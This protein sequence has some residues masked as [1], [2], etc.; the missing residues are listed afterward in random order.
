MRDSS[1]LCF[2]SLAQIRS[3]AS[4][5]QPSTQP[6]PFTQSY[7]NGRRVLLEAGAARTHQ[8][9]RQQPCVLAAALAP[10]RGHADHPR[11]PPG[12]ADCS[13]PNPQWASLSFGAWICLEVRQCSAAR[14][15]ADCRAQQGAASAD[16]GRAPF[17]SFDSA[18]A[19]TVASACTG[20]SSAARRWTSGAK[21]RSARRAHAHPAPASVR[22]LLTPL[23]PQMRLGGNRALNDFLASY[24]PGGGYETGMSIQQKVRSHRWLAPKVIATALTLASIDQY[25]TWAALQYKDK[26]AALSSSPPEPW[27]P[28]PAPPPTAQSGSAPNSR[29]A[30]AQGVRKARG[31]GNTGGIGSSSLSQET[32]EVDSRRAANE[33]FFSGLGD[34]NASRS[35]DLPPSQGRPLS[36]LSSL[37]DRMR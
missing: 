18:A 4:D 34:K 11:A 27:S 15:I 26:L 29:P 22:P 16:Q 32:D 30:S 24:G 35:T 17:L 1:W 19:C 23:V 12:C 31:F 13:N 10:A 33:T 5:Q 9:G 8:A 14:R 36:L 21:T 6:P 25:D 7:D 2:G 37:R 3:S 28:S 20:L